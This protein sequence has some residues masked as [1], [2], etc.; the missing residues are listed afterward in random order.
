MSDALVGVVVI[1]AIL[2]ILLSA[3]YSIAHLFH[4]PAQLTGESEWP[5]YKP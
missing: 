1:V 2:H 3:A 4:P 5:V